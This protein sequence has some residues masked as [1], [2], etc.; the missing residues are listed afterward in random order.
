MTP[1]VLTIGGFLGA[2]KTTLIAKAAGIL[3]WW[4]ANNHH[5]QCQMPEC[6][7]AEMLECCSQ[8]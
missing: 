5:I 2:G 1:V 7:N 6:Q 3:V 8:A 4:V